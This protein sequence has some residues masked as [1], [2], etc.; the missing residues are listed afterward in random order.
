MVHY[1]INFNTTL[2]YTYIFFILEL[3]E[4][5]TVYPYL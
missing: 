4:R 1:F 2:N 3:I 5:E